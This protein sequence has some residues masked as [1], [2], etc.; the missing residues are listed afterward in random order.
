MPH[1]HNLIELPGMRQ[2]MD[3]IGLDTLDGLNEQEL[4]DIVVFAKQLVEDPDAFE[5]T[6]PLHF[7][8]SAWA[9]TPDRTKSLYVYHNLYDSWSWIGGHADGQRDLLAVAQRELEEETGV[10][11]SRV[12]MRP[13]SL[14]MLTVSGHEKRGQYVSSH[15]HMNVTYLFEVD[16]EQPLKVKPDENSAVR[17]F[18]SEEIYERS[19]EPWFIERIYRKIIERLPNAKGEWKALGR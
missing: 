9:V 14:E 3:H 4:A 17:W 8:A 10:R 7:T 11:P 18:P 12:L 15:L 6:Q 19:T 1:R 5:R 13:I 16:E 2:L